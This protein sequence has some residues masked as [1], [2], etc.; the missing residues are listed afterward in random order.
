[1]KIIISIIIMI[2]IITIMMNLIMVTSRARTLLAGLRQR[3]GG[4][5]RRE[6]ECHRLMFQCVFHRFSMVFSH[7]HGS[8][9]VLKLLLEVARFRRSDAKRSGT[10][11]K[12]P[13]YRTSEWH[14]DKGKG[15]GLAKGRV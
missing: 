11:P 2:I 4:S 13:I 3:R 7:C 1:M 8:L 14:I 10:V 15:W 12:L 6:P 9:L 5:G